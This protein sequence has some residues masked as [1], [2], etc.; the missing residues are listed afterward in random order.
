MSERKNFEN[1]FETG[2]K[3]EDKDIQKNQGANKSDIS[4]DKRKFNSFYE[5][6]KEALLNKTNKLKKR[7]NELGKDI[8]EDVILNVFFD[9]P[10]EEENSSQENDINS[11]EEKEKKIHFKIMNQIKKRK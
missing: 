9:S 8:N 7:L 2:A 1:Q 3:M 11:E 5:E 6:E 4:K 10:S